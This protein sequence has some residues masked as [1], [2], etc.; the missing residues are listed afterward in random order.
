MD[1]SPNGREKLVG[2]LKLNS[3][4]SFIPFLHGSLAGYFYDGSIISIEKESFARIGL[5]AFDG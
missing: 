2:S 1:Q 5:C 3:F 4:I